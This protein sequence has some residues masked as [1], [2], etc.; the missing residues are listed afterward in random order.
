[1]A[2]TRVRSPSASHSS[3]P[4]VHQSDH[5]P[6][7]QYLIAKLFS[8][9]FE[10]P[11]WQITIKRIAN[12]VTTPGSSEEIRQFVE[13]FLSMFGPFASREDA[14]LKL[15]HLEPSEP[16]SLLRFIFDVYT[17]KLDG[18][19]MRYAAAK[20]RLAGL[21]ERSSFASAVYA[22]VL[23]SDDPH[24]SATEEAK[25]A[26]HLGLKGGVDSYNLPIP[27]MNEYGAHLA[28][29]ALHLDATASNTKRRQMRNN[30]R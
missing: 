9:R 21:A 7:T 13:L 30:N 12:L 24:N 11:D 2:S 29:T 6:E 14:M 8:M 15:E 4:S 22:S 19:K 28:A 25:N 5:R 18:S 20:T 26:H 16:V 23:R 10:S 3:R 27:S 1:M 17:S